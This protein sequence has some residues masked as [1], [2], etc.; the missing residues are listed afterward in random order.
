MKCPCG[1][2]REYDK[3]CGELHSGKVHNVTAEQLMR[4]R[5]C[6]FT[7]ADGAYL[8]NSHHSSTRPI[9]QMPEIIK[10]AKSVDWIGLEILSRSGG[11]LNDTIGTVQFKAHY[12]EKGK[13]DYI[14]E[15][16]EF[17][18]ENQRWVYLGHTK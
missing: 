10:W 2:N 1:L 3:C 11:N 5:Y 6:A 13:L 18:R 9:L 17:V 16:S 7:M 4:S 8:L 15:H 14:L 12:F